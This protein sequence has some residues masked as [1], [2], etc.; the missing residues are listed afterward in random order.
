MAGLITCKIC[1]AFETFFWICGVQESFWSSTIPRYVMLSE[2]LI[3]TPLMVNFL[4]LGK[5]SLWNFCCLEKKTT[6]VLSTEKES[7]FW[8]PHSTAMSILG[9]AMSTSVPGQKPLKQSAPSSANPTG[10]HGL[11]WFKSLNRGS[12]AKFQTLL[13][14]TSPCGVPHTGLIYSLAPNRSLTC[15][16][17]YLIILKLEKKY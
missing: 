4:S 15:T 13:L 3:S 9:W 11:S 7:P 10:A 12:K 14:R 1:L 17:V 8:A 2:G 16:F 6:L 5:T